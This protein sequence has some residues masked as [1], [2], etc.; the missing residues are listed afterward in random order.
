MKEPV[1]LPWAEREPLLRALVALAPG[2]GVAEHESD[3]PGQLL[4]Y[5]LPTPPF[6][7]ALDPNAMIIVGERGA[8]KTE[9]FRV[10]GSGKG[11]ETLQPK[12]GMSP[13]LVQG[14]GRFRQREADHPDTAAIARAVGS[15][16]DNRW[17]AFWIGL[18]AARL[19]KEGFPL[20]IPD[21]ARAALASPARV[22]A[23]F[24]HVLA[25]Y[26]E[27]I[28]AIDVLDA[29]LAT[30]EQL[31]LVA[32]DE[33][34][35]VS[36]DYASLF[37]PMR[38]LLALWLDRWRRWGNIRPKIIVRTDLWES[39]LLAF[40]D[41][42]KLVAHKVELEWRR[43][44]LYQM[45]VKRMLNTEA[46]NDFTEK[47]LVSARGLLSIPSSPVLGLYPHADEVAFAALI[48][49]LVGEYMGANARKGFSYEW[50]PNHVS[51]AQGRILPRPF[52]KLVSL[53]A[54]AA[55]DRGQAVPFASEPLLIPDDFFRAA[56]ETSEVRLQ[57]LI[58][59]RLWLGPVSRV[60]EE[61]SVPMDRSDVL[62]CL[63]RVRWS[64]AEDERPPTHDTAQ[65]LDEYLVPLGI[66]EHR[67]D[68]RY[69]VPDIYRHGLRMKRKGGVP[70]RRH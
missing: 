59:G 14:F 8:G 18:L 51:D 5:F 4:R 34:D 54:S 12:L 55:L 68:G 62:G 47:Q 19:M 52:L 70:R 41:A 3:D 21:S 30:Q 6:E 20:N 61:E 67:P 50:L 39:R 37:P 69:N 57:E 10:L 7:R 13:K 22:D 23:W 49:A 2:K 58:E 29:L 44:W 53:A 46:L 36:N 64:D 26:E 48:T 45:L 43:P 32:Y 11:F 63:E 65:I 60:F 28:A 9:L 40:P 24:P 38:A 25:Q 27:I 1:K 15:G 35:R 17:R 56:Q 66:F 42:S 16:D 33:L 31:V